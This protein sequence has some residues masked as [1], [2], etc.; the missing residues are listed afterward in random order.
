VLYL[1]DVVRRMYQ[2]EADALAMPAGR[3]ASALD[4]RN[5][6]RHV[7]VLRVFLARRLI[8]LHSNRPAPTDVS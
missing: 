8:A 3:E 6:V 7:G 2:L 4:D 1:A 5:L